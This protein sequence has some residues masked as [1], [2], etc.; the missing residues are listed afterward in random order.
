MTSSALVPCRGPTAST[1]LTT[2]SHSSSFL[3]PIHLFT[4]QIGHALA[5]DLLYHL[6]FDIINRL[7]RVVHCF[8][9]K[10]LDT[11]ST[12]LKSKSMEWREA[13]EAA[14][15]AKE[16]AA[17]NNQLR[18]VEEVGRAA[19]E[20]GVIGPGGMACPMGKDGARRGGRGG[21]PPG[22]VGAVLE[23]MNE[24]RMVE[25]DFWMQPFQN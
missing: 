20:R 2:T 16:A 22:W 7:L 3:L 19:M 10:Q 1:T 6:L 25:R 14:K 4:A 21:K 18:I 13:R 5:T 12:F 15:A 17:A 9:S 11:F 24:G 23:G 8:A